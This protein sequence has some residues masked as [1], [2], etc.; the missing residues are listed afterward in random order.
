MVSSKIDGQIEQL[1]EL[2]KSLMRETKRVGPD[3]KEVRMKLRKE[4]IPVWLAQTHTFRPTTKMPQFRLQPDEI[5]AIAAYIWQKGVT[6]QCRP[7][8]RPGDAA[9]GQQLLQQRGCLACHSIGEGQNLMGGDFAANLSRI[10][11][12]ENYDY[13]VRWI[14]NPR[15]RTRPY[16]PFEK[17]DLGPEDYAKHGLAVRLRSGS[18]AMPE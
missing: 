12:K 15:L 13:L 7:K 6:G 3:L 17:R 10:G 8:A 4:W 5:Q 18:L 14:S 2:T 16:C 9:H 1:D 11:E